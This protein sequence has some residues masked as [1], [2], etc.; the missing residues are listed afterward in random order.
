[1]VSPLMFR[2]AKRRSLGEC[3]PSVLESGVEHDDGTL[4]VC[5]PPEGE[6][7]GFGVETSANGAARIG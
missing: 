5:D 4:S 1:M 7:I 2:P 6:P 3:A